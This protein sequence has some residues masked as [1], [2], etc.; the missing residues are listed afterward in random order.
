MD[1]D[2]CQL[3]ADRVARVQYRIAEPG[4]VLAPGGR[5]L[6]LVDLTDVYMTFFLPA[7]QAGRVALGEEV[8]FHCAGS[9][10]GDAGDITDPGR[11]HIL[12]GSIEYETDL[13][14]E[15]YPTSLSG[16]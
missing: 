9:K 13:F 12:W 6:N 14:A 3:H 10:L 8:C 5:V 4:E 16:G 2:D 15:G 1:L 7:T 11:D